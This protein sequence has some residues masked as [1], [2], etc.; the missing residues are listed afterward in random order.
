MTTLWLLRPTIAVAMAKRTFFSSSCTWRYG[1]HVCY[2]R[3]LL[4]I[5]KIADFTTVWVSQR[6]WSFVLFSFSFKPNMYLLRAYTSWPFCHNVQLCPEFT[7]RTW[8]GHEDF[9]KY[10]KFW[11]L[12]SPLTAGLA[13]TSSWSSVSLQLCHWGSG[14]PYG[15]VLLPPT[16]GSCTGRNGPN[17]LSPRPPRV[18]IQQ[19]WGFSPPRIHQVRTYSTNKL[20]FYL[21]PFVKRLPDNFWRSI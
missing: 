20:L 2:Q 5:G 9:F 6:N 11:I 17:Q 8:K 10:V 1:P 15:R 18:H 4:L 3:P 13:T 21:S 19:L 16:H 14:P 12:F 7:I